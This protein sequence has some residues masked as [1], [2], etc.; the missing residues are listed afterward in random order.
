MKIL[1][2][3][4]LAAMLMFSSAAFAASA[5]VG[6]LN[7]N[8]ASAE[9]IAEGMNGIGDSK[10]KAIVQYRQKHGKFRSLQDLEKVDG[11]GAKTVEKNRDK[12][13]L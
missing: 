10:A 2:T 8:T 9:Q 5:T 6:K 7:I 11:V 4:F 1:H 13:S 3:L 12:I